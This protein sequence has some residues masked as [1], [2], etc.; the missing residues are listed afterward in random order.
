MPFRALY[1]RASEDELRALKADPARLG[2]FDVASRLADG[3]ALDLGR[4]WDEL[5]CLLD[6]GIS[7]PEVGP[8]VGE[9]A[10]RAEEGREL[11][12]YV[13]RSRVPA[14]AAAL[15]LT[16]GEFLGLYE[17]GDEGTADRPFVEHTGQWTDGADRLYTKL[18]R[19]RAHYESAAAKGEGMLVRLARAD[20]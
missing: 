18:Q 13:E 2:A 4:G 12:T 16:H 8:T 10:L 6:G 9:H 17:V 3:R 20:D 19:L 15:S 14:M 11:W 5:G 7:P 1:I